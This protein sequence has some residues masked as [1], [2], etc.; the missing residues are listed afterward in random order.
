LFLLNCLFFRLFLLLFSFAHCRC[1]PEDLINGEKHCKNELRFFVVFCCCGGDIFAIFHNYCR[2]FRR[3]HH[4]L[5][6]INETNFNL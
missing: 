2:C 6:S 5:Q 3:F 4:P 1:F